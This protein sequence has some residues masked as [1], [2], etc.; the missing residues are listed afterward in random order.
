MGWFSS[1]NELY[2]EAMEC[3]NRRDYDKAKNLLVKAIDKKTDKIDLAV[4]TINF[5]NMNGNLNNS[6][7]YKSLAGSLAKIPDGAFQIGL[8]TFDKDSLIKEC[9]AMSAC[10]N[11]RTAVANSEDSMVSKAQAMIEAAKLVQMNIGQNSL[12]ITEFFTKNVQSGQKIATTLLAEANEL[13]AESVVHRDTK[14]AAEY[15]QIAFNF[16]KQLGESG[17]KNQ[18]LINR[19]IASCTCWFCGRVA[20]GDGINFVKM[21]CDTIPNE[22]GA[23]L[24]KSVDEENKK[25]FVCRSC[26][27]AMSRRADDISRGYYNE[28]LREMRE[29]EARIN[30]KIAAIEAQIGGVAL[31]SMRR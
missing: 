4:A 2:D 7:K 9:E 13:L 17:E 23:D 30:M 14:K 10:I 5:L 15:Q 1:G 12:L 24:S 25:I 31:A 8:T 21:S 3:I 6:S 16:R 18:T 20:V 28:S 29:M 22:E 27:T 26:Y 19:Y 11:A